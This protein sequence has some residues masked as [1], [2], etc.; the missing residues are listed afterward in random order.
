MGFV[1]LIGGLRWPDA[2]RLHGP[3]ESHGCRED[4]QSAKNFQEQQDK[5]RVPSNIPDAGG[6]SDDGA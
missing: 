3:P 4:Q 1:S 6:H 5:S 2:R